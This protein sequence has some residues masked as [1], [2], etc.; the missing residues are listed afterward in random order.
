MADDVDL[1]TRH[2]E[3]QLARLVAAARAPVPA[4]VPGE[5]AQCGDDSPRLVGGRCAP[6]RDGRR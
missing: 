3:D 4:G 6:C 2:A 5:C 1:A